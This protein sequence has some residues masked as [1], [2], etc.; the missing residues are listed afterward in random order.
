MKDHIVR[1][2]SWFEKPIIALIF[3]TGIGAFLRIYNLGF[4]SLWLDEALQFHIS[5]GAIG[6]I[7]RYNALYNGAPPLYSL[8]IRAMIAI[9]TSEEILRTVSCLAGIATIPMMYYLATQFTSY[10]VALVA[11]L[12]VALSP[13]QIMYSQQLREYS[14]TLLLAQAMLCAFM[15]FLQRPNWRTSLLFGLLSMVSICT[16]YGLAL[17]VLALNIVFFVRV[18][19]L[20]KRIRALGLWAVA[21]VLGLFAVFAVYHLSLK[22]HFTPEGFG[23]AGSLGYA[24]WDGTLKS[25]FTIVTLNTKDIFT[26]AFPLAYLI[27]ALVIIGVIRMAMDKDRVKSVAVWMLVTPMA[28]TFIAALFRSYP[29]V[30]GRHTI[31]LLPMIYLFVT[32]GISFL[33]NLRY[34]RYITMLFLVVL[35]F[36]GA[37]ESAAYLVSEGLEPMRPIVGTLESSLIKSDFI[38]V[39]YGAMPAFAYYFRGN[40]H[41][42]T[43]GTAHFRNSDNYRRELNRMLAQKRRIWIVLSHVYGLEGDAILGYLATHEKIVKL[44]HRENKVYLFLAY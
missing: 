37:R 10:R 44:V 18:F 41:P 43:E 36:Q 24:Y 19:R 14:L 29:Y 31:F 35:T 17:F 5:N 2:I 32:L 15:L 27:V 9:G 3:I 12:L 20:D 7:L 39:Y 4:K 26:F 34:G 6:H 11:A 8:L 30:G 40:N 42:W 16:Q 21:Q 13:S 25:L 1:I 22:Y 28:V 38:Y 23:A 33:S